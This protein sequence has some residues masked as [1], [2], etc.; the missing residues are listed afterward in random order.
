[1]AK[2][3]IDE[4]EIRKIGAAIVKEAKRVAKYDQGT[5]MRSIAFTYVKGVMIF[6]QIY[7]G[8]YYENSQLEK[9]AAKKVPRG[10]PWKII[11]T[12][13]GGGTYETGRTRRGRA[14]KS[15]VSSLLNV[16]SSINIRKLIAKKKAKA[17][18]KD[19]GKKE[20]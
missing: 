14:S 1:M 2:K 20:D 12:K 10:V 6:R 16:A 5:L 3:E 15:S 19:N 18:K 11:L 4:A 9:I 8:V 7:Y 17:A 13:F